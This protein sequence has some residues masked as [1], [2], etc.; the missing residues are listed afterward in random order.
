MS[1][2]KDD[3]HCHATIMQ[4][5]LISSIVRIARTIFIDVCVCLCACMDVI[6]THNIGHLNIHRRVYVHCAV[7]F[8]LLSALKIPSSI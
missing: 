7:L 2:K 1:K 8:L 4:V 5:K 6:Y 3:K